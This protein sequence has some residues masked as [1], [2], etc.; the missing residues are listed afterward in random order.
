[1]RKSADAGVSFA[2]ESAQSMYA[3]FGTG[4]PGFNRDHGVNFPSLVVDR[5]TGPHRGRV[6]MAYNESVNWYDDGL[7][8]GGTQAEVEPNGSTAMA[9]PFV[10]GQHLT[11]SISPSSDT[12]YWSFTAT[13]G[14]DYIF[15]F[16]P[17]SS[18]KYLIR[19]LCTDGVTRLSYGGDTSAGGNYGFIVWTAP[20]NGTYY[21]YV[22]TTA[23]G[24]GTYTVETGVD[25]PSFGEHARDQRDGMVTFSDNAVTWSTPVIVNTDPALYDNYFSEVQV[26]CEGYPYSIWY[27]FRDSP[28]AKC[29]G[30][31]NVYIS[32]SLDGGTT[33]AANQVVTSVGTNFTA[34][35]SNLQPNMGDYLGL[36]GG[37]RL[38]MAWADGRLGDAD[39]W[40]ANLAA[41]PALTCPSGP[42]VN[43]GQTFPVNFTL[44]N[45]NVMFGNNYTVALASEHPWTIAPPSQ[46]LTLAASASGPAN[47]TVTAPDTFPTGTNNLTLTVT[48]QNGGVCA[49]CVVTVN[50]IGVP[51]SVPPASGSLA[52]AGAWPNPASVAR[53]VSVA[54]SLAGTG[55]A[56]IDLIDLAGRRV[57]SSEVGGMGPGSH[58]LS[59]S[60][61]VSRLAAGMYILRLTEGGR[62]LTSKV[63][64]ER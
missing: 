55:P 35:L 41:A 4:A 24:S 5:S 32:R 10:P 59:W 8:G 33:W 3:N 63:V 37:G 19:I 62:S 26:T 21:F 9:T 12:D 45:A 14:T 39:A 13:Q 6:Y 57:L 60:R 44:Q 25:A 53:G 18:F 11:G 38:I 51:S 50:V 58:V 7:G 17:G 20:A 52:L 48:S 34:T 27:D 22:Q 1:V 54:F 15:W 40:S 56:R 47:F 36:Y 2:V 64:L 29:G 46:P 16:K 43:S 42:T 30:V 49:R 31:A 61:E 23:G 28:A